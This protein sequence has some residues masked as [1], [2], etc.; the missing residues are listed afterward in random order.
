MS[1]KILVTGGAG[2]IGSHVVDMLVKK[3]CTVRV[4]DDLSSGAFRNIEDHMVN[5]RVNFIHGSILDQDVVTKALRGV[6]QV[7]H[8]AAIVNVPFSIVHPELTYE[9][10]VH[11]TKVLLDQCVK[12]GVERFVFA[13]SCAVYGE[14]SYVPID[15]V[16]P[17]EPLSCRIPLS[18]SSFCVCERSASYWSRMGTQV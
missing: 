5:D 9:V 15:E 2:F 12:K 1:L 7:V 11:G 3:G 16:H 8:L 4:L 6:N 17:T 14:A 13:S 10:N 18:Q